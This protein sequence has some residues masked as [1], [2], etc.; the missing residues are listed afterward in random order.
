MS[1]FDTESEQYDNW[2]EKHPATYQS[3]INAVRKALPENWENLHSMEIGIGTGRFAIPFNIKEGIEPS[4]AM[5]TIAQRKGINAIEGSAEKI[6]FNNDSFDFTLMV[7]TI[8]FVKDAATSC[9]EAYR[10]LKP[11]GSIIIGIV[12]KESKLGK[13]YEARKENS[14]FYKN[15]TFFS[16]KDIIKLLTASGFS[17]LQFYQTLIS[18]PNELT[19]AEP[20]IPGHEKGAFVVISGKKPSDKL[21]N[22]LQI[23]D[24]ITGRT[25]EERAKLV[26]MTLGRTP[27]EIKKAYRT[28][29]Q[30]YHP[31]TNTGDTEAFQLI[32]EAYTLLTNGNIPKKPLLANDKLILRVTKLNNIAPLFDK[33]R[34]WEDA[35]RERREQFYGYGVI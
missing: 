10:I 21:S 15:A 32:N 14:K 24:D 8:C 33:Q 26:L 20:A 35:E 27:S 18:H 30:E 28:L 13:E 1:I 7:T 16:V 9:K 34:V 2:F 3:E 29:A 25:L 31:D 12:N 22:T 5:R 23:T 6:P 17:D 4:N 11:G 19:E